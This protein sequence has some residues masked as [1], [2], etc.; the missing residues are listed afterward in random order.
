MSDPAKIIIAAKS[1]IDSISFDDN[2]AMIAG[3]YMGGNGGLISRETLEKADA[4]RRAIAVAES[5]GE[6]K[7]S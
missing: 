3:K 6:V 5:G 1:L 7:I 4:L 2:G